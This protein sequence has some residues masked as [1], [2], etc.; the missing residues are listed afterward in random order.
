MTI[1]SSTMASFFFFFLVLYFFLALGSIIA[2]V[3]GIG[4]S[5]P[6]ALD[7]LFPPNALKKFQL[8]QGAYSYTTFCT[9]IHLGVIP[10]SPPFHS[11]SY[12]NTNTTCT[13][14]TTHLVK[15]R[16]SNL[17]HNLGLFPT[18]KQVGLKTTADFPS[19]L[20]PCRPGLPSPIFQPNHKLCLVW[21]LNTSK[22]TPQ[23]PFLKSSLVDT[24]VACECIKSRIEPSPTL[25][26]VTQATSK[27][28]P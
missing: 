10:S 21:R 1:N 12:L 13:W 3:L 26:L 22:P 28:I 14:K 8:T 24:Y 15:L 5:K 25:K 16:H 7:C 17:P 11:C 2:I 20:R 18:F 6:F 23:A 27:A 9:F 19:D 4:S